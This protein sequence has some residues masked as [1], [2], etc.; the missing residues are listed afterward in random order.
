MRMRS[1]LVERIGRFVL[2]PL[3]LPGLL[4]LIVIVFCFFLYR[5]QTA[6]REAALIERESGRMVLSALLFQKELRSLSDNVLSLADGDGL[7]AYVETGTEVQRTRALRRAVFY[8]RQQPE[9]DQLRFIDETGHERMRVNRDGLVVPDSELQDK[10]TRSYFQRAIALDR[11]QLYISV[12]DLNVEK[13]VVEIPYKPVLRFASPVYDSA[14]KKRGVYVINYLGGEAID[15]IRQMRAPVAHRFRVLNSNGYWLKSMS[16]EKDWG[17][18]FPER[19]GLTLANQDPALW[20]RVRE[21]TVGWSELDGGLFSWMRLDF[22]TCGSV[23]L[24]RDQIG[25]DEN[26]V[27]FASEITAAERAALAHNDR[28]IFLALT[29]VL[30]AAVLTGARQYAARKESNAALRRSEQSLAV[31]LY[32]IGDAVIATDLEGLITRMNHRAEQFTGWSIEEAWGLP[33]G[34]VLKLV[35]EETSEPIPSGVEEMLKDESGGESDSTLALIARDGTRRSVLRSVARIQDKDRKQ[36]LGVVLILR[37][38]S[39]ARKLERARSHFAERLEVANKE[40]ESFSYSVSHDLRAPLRHIQGYV[41]LLTRE[42]EG[43]LTEKEQRYLSTISHAARDMGTLIDDLLSFSRMGR[44]ELRETEVDAR[45]LVDSVCLDL[46]LVLKGR[47]IEWK[48]AELPRVWG[49][50]SMLRQVFA[51]LIDNAV[52]YTR[53]RP[54]AVIE[55]GCIGEEAG[56]SV[57]RVRDNGAGFDMRYVGK[58]FGVFQRLHRADEFEGT[59]IGLANV[60]RIVKRH[61][62]RI[63]AEGKVGEGAA[64]YFTLKNVTHTA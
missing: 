8:S 7:K 48:I 20:K 21:E 47:S 34:K 50:R 60:Q 39:E 27:V 2:H 25:T 53:K 31:T 19:K 17:F 15:S 5:W 64:I 54:L 13:G 61:G 24:S 9:Y 58:L 55:I 22:S 37:D 23:S 38:V 63:W 6:Y 62:G 40:L 32:S 16:P 11:G 14:G 57:F 56:Y 52:K 41:D 30:L 59:G 3:R 29:V 12:F 44:M 45:E 4:S 35:N 18:M 28:M 26:F 33:C 46:E 42:A 43:Q 10:S 49:D 36:I 51:N 1:R